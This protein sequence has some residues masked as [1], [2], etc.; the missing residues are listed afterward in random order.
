[1]FRNSHSFVTIHWY[2]DNSFKSYSNVLTACVVGN[3][4]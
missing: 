1:M 3:F 4:S 2:L